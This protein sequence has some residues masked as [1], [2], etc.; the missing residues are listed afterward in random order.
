[1]CSKPHL[2]YASRTFRSAILAVSLLAGLA[3]RP[4][5]AGNLVAGVGREE[6]TPP[7]GLPDWAIKGSTFREVLSPLYTRVLVLGDGSRKVAI[8][9]WDLANT[10]EETVAKVRG[11][12][13]EAT[14]IPF[15]DILVHAAHTHSAPL[16]PWVDA[17]RIPMDEDHAV[18]ANP[19]EPYRLWTEK[20][21]AASVAAAKAANASLK[22]SSLE[23]GRALVPEWQ[24]NRRT[25]KPDGKVETL[26]VPIDPYTMPNGNRFGPM[27]PTLTVLVLKQGGQPAITL[28][29]YPCHAVSVYPNPDP[30]SAKY[31]SSKAISADWPGYAAGQIE[32]RMGGRAIFL[33]GCAGDQV[34]ARRGV[35][36]AKEMGTLIAARA[37]AAAA[38]GLKVDVDRIETN[39]GRVGL[40][41]SLAQRAEKGTDLVMAEVQ[42]FVLGPVAIVALPGEP[43][44]ELAMAIQKASPYPHTIVMGYSNGGGVMYVG[45]PGELAMGGYGADSVAHGTDECGVFLVNTAVRLLREVAAR[46]AEHLKPKS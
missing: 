43:M 32:A 29:N 30:G 41:L 16:S 9:Q 23:I 40:P 13:S 25:R 24:Y 31:E 15:G 22:P 19:P 36:A 26:F 27:D 5:V 20:L 11:L 45:M 42:T 33:Q 46:P 39:S 1:M 17:S 7:M 4:A 3:V 21:Y 2:A 10:R 6:I 38:R 12:V 35:D 44:I 14:G 8:V 34:P 37:T 28:F 18:L